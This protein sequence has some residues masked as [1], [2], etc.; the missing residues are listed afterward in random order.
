MPWLHLFV[1][2][3]RVPDDAGQSEQCSNYRGPKGATPMRYAAEPLNSEQS[4]VGGGMFPPCSIFVFRLQ[5]ALTSIVL[6]MIIS[7]DSLEVEGFRG[8]KRLA[9]HTVSAAQHVPSELRPFRCFSSGLIVTFL[10]YDHS[11][12]CRLQ[13]APPAHTHIKNF[14]IASWNDEFQWK[15][16]FLFNFSS[17]AMLVSSRL[18]RRKKRPK[19]YISCLQLTY[20]RIVELGR[21]AHTR[22]TCSLITTF[23]WQQTGHSHRV[24]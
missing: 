8:L 17:T 9:F 1:R 3:G 5:L 21:A 23:C 14:G 20:E 24:T 6:C 13:L 2:C 10:Q 12:Q 18:Q 4:E 7:A 15:S 19:Q 16:D 22:R 11:Q